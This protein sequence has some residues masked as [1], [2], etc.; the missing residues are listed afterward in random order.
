MTRNAKTKIWDHVTVSDAITPQG[1]SHPI[2]QVVGH[3]VDGAVFYVN[4]PVSGTRTDSAQLRAEDRLHR[5][6][7]Y[8]PSFEESQA[9]QAAQEDTDDR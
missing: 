1:F 6:Y 5:D 4:E 3:R 9:E 8:V 2:V 7:S